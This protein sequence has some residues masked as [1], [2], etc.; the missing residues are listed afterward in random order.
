M[1]N[2]ASKA[3]SAVIWNTGFNLFRDGLQF[4]T[5]L[6]LVRLLPPEAYG[7]FGL[8][9]S[10]IGFISIFAFGNFI[11]HVLQVKEDGEALFQEHFTAGA[12]LNISMCAVTNLVAIGLRWFPEWSP[13]APFLH[14][15]SLNFLFEWPCEVRRKMIE[16][17]FDWKTLR[18]LHSFG[19][20]L[21]GSLA[22]GMAWA[23]FGTYALLVPG[24]AVTLPF[25]IDLFFRLRWRPTWSWCWQRYKPSFDF[26]IARI[27]SGLVLNGRQL[28][29]SG[30]LA[31]ILGFTGLGILNRSVGLA[32]LF[33]LK[34]A[35]QLVYAIYPILT[36]VEDK[37]GNA[38]RV[39]SLVLQTVIW[40]TLPLA[41]S[42]AVLASPV[43]RLVYGEKWLDVIPLVP[44]AMAWGAASAVF[45]AAYMLL[46]AR[47]KQKLCFMADILVL[48]GSAMSLWLALPLGIKFYLM[49]TTASQLLASTCLLVH[50]HRT[51]SLTIVGWAAPLVAGATSALV[52]AGLSLAL[53][54]LIGAAPQISVLNA[55][56]WGMT[57]LIMYGVT[58]RVVFCSQL[59][60]LLHYFPARGLFQKLL[61]LSSR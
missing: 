20:V 17:E 31:A 42:F 18:I 47:Q 19:L 30:L 46:L 11:A 28:L 9:T 36:R 13:V 15:M 60:S 33:C 6:V 27:G 58:L 61:L 21:T 44:W 8:V 53:F 24:M 7:H 54:S 23:G 5:M 2:F 22:L 35:T 40:T 25:I 50:L 38:A 52:A 59:E 39:G 37:E 29:E 4:A 57:F 16:R 14:V 49:G 55:V 12:V 10:I 1:S 45:H 3:R 43:V 26:A 48:I 41:V 32:Q 51:N 34:I 56:A